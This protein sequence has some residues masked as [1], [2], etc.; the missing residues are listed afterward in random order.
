MRVADRSSLL[1]RNADQQARWVFDDVHQ[2]KLIALCCAKT[3]ARRPHAM[4]S[5][6]P[7]FIASS[8]GREKNAGCWCSRVDRQWLD[9]LQPVTGVPILQAASRSE[10]LDVFMQHDALLK[11]CVDQGQAG[12][13]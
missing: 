12:L 3:K 9:E 5:F 7:R 6:D 13:C 11:P 4:T 2:Q 8:H 1:T 10:V